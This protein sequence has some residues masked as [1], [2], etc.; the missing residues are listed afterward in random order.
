M[1]E[2]ATLA[3]SVAAVSGD[4]V[5]LVRRGRAPARGLYAFPG[6]RVEPGESLETAARRE[7]AEETGLL[8]ERLARLDEMLLGGGPNDVRLYRLTVFRADRVSGRLRAGDDA[9]EVAWYSPEAMRGLPM[10][11]ST[12]T[13]ARRLLG[14]PCP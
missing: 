3:V 6:G 4:R 5:L 13:V 11:G 1:D 8:A 12:L 9:A 2:D 14:K 7:L 10:T